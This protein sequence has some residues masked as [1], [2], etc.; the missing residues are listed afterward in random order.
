M[1][2]LQVP[3]TGGAWSRIPLPLAQLGPLIWPRPVKAADTKENPIDV[4]RG[5]QRASVSPRS[6]APMFHAGCLWFLKGENGPWPSFCVS[7]ETWLCGRWALGS[8]VSP[9]SSVRADL[10]ACALP[11]SQAAPGSLALLTSFLLTEA[12]GPPWFAWLMDLWVPPFPWSLR[13]CLSA[14]CGPCTQSRPGTY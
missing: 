13:T 6:L 2:G 4:R 14:F 1:H 8:L 9:Q 5:A 10:S 12:P 11:L 3:G 7:T